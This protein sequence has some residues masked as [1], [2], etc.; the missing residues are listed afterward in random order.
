ML[1]LSVFFTLVAISVF[2]FPFWNSKC[3]WFSM[4]YVWW[5]MAFRRYLVLTVY[6]CFLVDLEY[7]WCPWAWTK[8]W[9]LMSVEFAV[10]FTRLNLDTLYIISWFGF[11]VSTYLWLCMVSVGSH[12]LVWFKG[13]GQT[14]QDAVPCMIH[15]SF[16]CL[17]DSECRDKI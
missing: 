2:F 9:I 4:W 13:H 3:L 10:F 14:I 1:H 12:R 15:Y 5:C 6:T 16:C 11:Y 17:H 8:I 7:D